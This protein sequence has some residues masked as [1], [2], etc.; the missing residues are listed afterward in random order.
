MD[1]SSLPLRACGSLGQ[2][3][4][5]DSVVLARRS[6]LW[7]KIGG[8]SDLPPRQVYPQQRKQPRYGHGRSV[9][10]RDIG[11]AF[12]CWPEKFAAPLLGDAAAHCDIARLLCED[13]LSAAPKQSAP[14][15]KLRLIDTLSVRSAPQLLR[16]SNGRRVHGRAPCAPSTPAPIVMA[17][18]TSTAACRY[19]A[20]LKARSLLSSA[21]LRKR[22]CTN[23]GSRQHDAVFVI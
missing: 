19:V 20:R 13:H 18:T 7:V 8:E 6:P 9:P 12:R 21:S 2:Q 11:P 14:P 3:R 17:E 16:R 10:I 23:S 1:L 5:S 4:S 15:S 22:S